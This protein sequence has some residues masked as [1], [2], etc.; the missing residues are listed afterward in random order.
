MLLQGCDSVSDDDIAGTEGGSSSGEYVPEE[1][2]GDD[3]QSLAPPMSEGSTGSTPDYPGE[4]D[5]A[6]DRW[7][8]TC[9][10]YENHPISCDEWC[11]DGGMACIETREFGEA[12]K[13]QFTAHACDSKVWGDVDIDGSVQCICE[14]RPE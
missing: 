12:C 6:N 7:H 1:S 8:G 2:T 11:A 9:E 13:G 4:Y 3:G 14:G 5:E 10:N